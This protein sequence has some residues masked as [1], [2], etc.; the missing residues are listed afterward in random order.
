MRRNPRNVLYSVIKIDV[1]LIKFP[2]F[3]IPEAFVCLSLIINTNMYGKACNTET[4]MTLWNCFRKYD[5]Y[6]YIIYRN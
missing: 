2:C 1:P 4:V 5:I 6:L 3:D